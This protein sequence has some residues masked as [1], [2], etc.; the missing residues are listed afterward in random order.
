MSAEKDSHPERFCPDR[1]CLWRVV[2][3]RGFAPCPKH[4]E[5]NLARTS[6]ENDVG[7]VG[8]SSGAPQT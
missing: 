4:M 1:R 2:R 6:V 5:Q 3:F 8:A 7:G